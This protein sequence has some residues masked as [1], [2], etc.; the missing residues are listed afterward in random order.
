MSKLETI[1][2]SA[3]GFAG[4]NTQDSP[5]T[6]PIEFAEVADNCV[7][8]KFGRIAARKGYNVV[9]TTGAPVDP[10]K[11]IGY[12]EDADPLNKTIYSATDSAIY[13]GTSTMTSLYTTGVTAGN[14]QY[15][16]FNE[17]MI[18]I[19]ANHAPLI[20]SGGG[21]PALLNQ[22]VSVTGDNLTGANVG[23]AAFGRLWLADTT[24]QKSRIYWSDLLIPG[25]FNAG[26]AGQI[27]LNDVW[28]QGQDQITALAAHNGFLVIFGRHSIVVYQ[29][30][31]SPANMVLAD[32]VSSVGCVARD[33]VQSTGTDLLFLSAEGVRSFGRTIQE[34]SMPERDISGTVR[35]DI[36]VLT[37]SSDMAQIKSVYSPKDSFYALLFGGEAVAYVF[38]VRRPLPNGNLRATRWPICPFTCFTRDWDNDLIFVGGDSGVGTYAGYN[39]NGNTY[40]MSYLTHQNNFDLPLTTKMLKKIRP[41]IIGTSN[42]N[43]V[44]RWGFDFGTATNSRVLSLKQSSNSQYGIDEYGLAEYGTADIINILNVNAFGAGTKIQ[45]GL[46]VQINGEPFS[47]QEL[48][49]YARMGRTTW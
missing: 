14:W 46:D 41:I 26:S 30:A 45:V 10:I 37:Q 8:D 24:A 11:S 7:I 40:Q 17:Q 27:D 5:I 18:F 36:S 15:L 9:T 3:P 47:V 16:N 43:A 48:T 22:T 34:D 13:S 23:L 21:T 28:P 4:L 33:S 38:D 49:L 42:S 1:T 31:E 20:A 44:L 32:T 29:G 6:M 19:Q 25:T 35:D 2:V 39:D 12:F